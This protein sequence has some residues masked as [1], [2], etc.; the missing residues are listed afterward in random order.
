MLEELKNVYIKIPL[1]QAIKEIS[2]FAKT[3]KELSTQGSIRK[4]KE[5]K[6]IQLV[7]RIA[8]IMIGKKQFKNI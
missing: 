4:R 5:I 3:I 6:I 7:R 2:I 1:L 8:D